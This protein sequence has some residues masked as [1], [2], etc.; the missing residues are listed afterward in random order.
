[1]TDMK[2]LVL[3]KLA[4]QVSF[5]VSNEACC[6]IVMDNVLVAVSTNIAALICKCKIVCACVLF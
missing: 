1:M 4:M 6:S 2:C 5:R 3:L